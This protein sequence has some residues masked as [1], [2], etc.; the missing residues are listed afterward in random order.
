[1]DA[2]GFADPLIGQRTTFR[3]LRWSLVDAIVL[4]AGV[5]LISGLLV[6][7]T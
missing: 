5:G 6:L 1:M 7:A 4:A 3:P 2:R